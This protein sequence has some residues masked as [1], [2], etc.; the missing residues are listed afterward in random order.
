MRI[1]G[2]AHVQLGM[3]S[4]GEDVAR[5]FY[6]GLLGLEEIPRPDWLS[7]REGV[8]FRVA[9]RNST[10]GSK[11]RSRRAAAIPLC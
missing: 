6:G 1:L 9:A 10:A 11:A 3:T 7:E 4:G 8:W 5:G 2:I